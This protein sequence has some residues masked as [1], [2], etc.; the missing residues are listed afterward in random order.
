[1]RRWIRSVKRVLSAVTSALRSEPILVAPAHPYQF[2]TFNKQGEVTIGADLS[3][4]GGVA[5]R[6]DALETANM[7]GACAVGI[8]EKATGHQELLALT[9]EVTPR[10]REVWQALVV[11]ATAL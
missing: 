4:G 11:R 3:L 10:I 6:E 9:G 1:M 7:I 2:S 8:Y 5:S